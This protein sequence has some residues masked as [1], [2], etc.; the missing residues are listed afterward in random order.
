MKKI[1]FIIEATHWRISGYYN[2]PQVK[3]NDFVYLDNVKK[4]RI[5][6]FVISPK[7]LPDKLFKTILD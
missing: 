3:P 7:F 5:R 1:S 6:L 4:I 2:I